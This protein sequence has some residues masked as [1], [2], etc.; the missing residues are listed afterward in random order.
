MDINTRLYIS[1]NKR[2]YCCILFSK[3]Q[4][5]TSVKQRLTPKDNHENYLSKHIEKCMII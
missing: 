4:Y 2:T 5:S 1:R 3:P